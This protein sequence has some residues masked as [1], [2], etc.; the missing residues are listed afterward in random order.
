MK[1]LAQDG[2]VG[3]FV[4]VWMDHGWMYRSWMDGWMD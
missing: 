1:V 2:W 3:G 4:D